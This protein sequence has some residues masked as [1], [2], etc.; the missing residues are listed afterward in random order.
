MWAT[1]PFW[2]L[3]EKTDEK[4]EFTNFGYPPYFIEHLLNRENNEMID[5]Y[6]SKIC[7]K[8]NLK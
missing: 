4:F 3:V 5:I 2:A 7:I 1:P 6:N 8:S